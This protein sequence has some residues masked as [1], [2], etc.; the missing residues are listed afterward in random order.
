MCIPMIKKSLMRHEW[1]RQDGCGKGE[2]TKSHPTQVYTPHKSELGLRG[3][4]C[5]ESGAG[6]CIFPVPIGGQRTA[7]AELA[8][9]T[10]I[11][12]SRHA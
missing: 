10:R 9:R 5:R 12:L 3:I 1:M 7:P 11:F 8:E 2:L 4:S 6:Y